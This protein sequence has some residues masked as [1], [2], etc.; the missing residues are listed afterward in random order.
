MA[1]VG[2]EMGMQREVGEK[3]RGGERERERSDGA[4]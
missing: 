1:R 3:E 4:L 2:G